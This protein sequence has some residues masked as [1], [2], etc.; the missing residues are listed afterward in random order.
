VVNQSLTPGARVGAYMWTNTQDYLFLY[1][2]QP[3]IQGYPLLVACLILLYF[4]LLYYFT[5][6]Y[7]EEFLLAQLTSPLS[8]VLESLLTIYG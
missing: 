4:I 2:G 5:L 8:Q 6:F 3:Y 1:G 7:F